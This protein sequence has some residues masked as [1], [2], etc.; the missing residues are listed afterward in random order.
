M[1]E[2]EIEVAGQKIK[3]KELS[4]EKQLELN[5][6]ENISLLKI[7]KACIDNPEILDKIN[8]KEGLIILKTVNEINGWKKGDNF[9]SQQEKE[10]SGK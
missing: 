7:I 5:E 8:T 1:K 6:E 9:L 4:F 2:I 3:I 10:K